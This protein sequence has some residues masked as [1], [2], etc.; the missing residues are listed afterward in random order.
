MAVPLLRDNDARRLFETPDLFVRNL[1]LQGTDTDAI[2]V[3]DSTGYVV[4]MDRSCY[5]E[6]VFLDHRIATLDDLVWRVP[7][8]EMIEQFRAARPAL[9][10]LRF[11][12]HT[13]FCGS[14]LLCRCLD[15]E[16][17]VL[18]YKE[19]FVLHTY[20]AIRRQCA[21]QLAASLEDPSLLDLVWASIQKT[22]GTAEVAVVKPTDSCS[23]VAGELL[24]HQPDAKALFLYEPFEAFLISMLKSEA[25]RQYL[26]GNLPRAEIDL[27]Q[28]DLAAPL[29][30]GNLSDGQA[31]AVVW[32]AM[33]GH[34]RDVLNNPDLDARSLD[35]AVFFAQPLPIVEKVAEFFQLGLAEE[36][37]MEIERSGRLGGH[38]KFPGTA[39]DADARRLE[40][41]R[42]EAEFQGP[43]AEG[44]ELLQAITADD[45]VCAPLPRSIAD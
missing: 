14:T 13:A 4:R 33:M 39:F 28:R 41:S 44:V 32:L 5:T 1:Q 40:R 43:L 10:P 45:A 7:L 16:G 11:I 25:A 42:W 23:N 18:A 6:S 27:R 20:S 9:R 19:P 22:Y 36:H 8:G 12:F 15:T 17:L 37:I 24:Q 26:R 30:S 35:A 38:A 21:P 34:C 31:A 2:R 3:A 29:P